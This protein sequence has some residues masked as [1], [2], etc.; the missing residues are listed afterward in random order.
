MK[1]IYFIILFI[2]ISFSGNCHPHLNQFAYSIIFIGSFKNDII[3]ISI[4]KIS[5]LNQYKFDNSNAKTKGNLSLTQNDQE[6]EIYYNG[7]KKV[8]P[9]ISVQYVLDVVITV[10]KEIIKT[11]V[12]LRKGKVILI[13]YKM[14][15]N[16]KNN[17][18]I[19]QIAEP[20]V[21]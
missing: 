18:G 10:N 13:D 17:I 4:N 6:I 2:T 9:K 15:A 16:K 7:T 1:K 11:K 12:D 21:L 3:S 19:E 14:L 5:L 8:K 20:I